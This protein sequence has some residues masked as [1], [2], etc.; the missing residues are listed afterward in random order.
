MV[1]YSSIWLFL[2]YVPYLLDV[3]KLYNRDEIKYGI[4]SGYISNSF[5]QSEILY[6]FIY[7]ILGIIFLL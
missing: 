1:V 6:H 2:Q 4:I 5:I 7:G 3:I